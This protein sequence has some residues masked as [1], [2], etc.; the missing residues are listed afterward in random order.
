MMMADHRI[1]SYRYE[2]LN[3]Q[4]QV[5]GP[6]PGVKTGGTL[7]F[8]DTADIRGQGGIEVQ[9][10]GTDWTKHLIRISYVRQGA[11]PLPLITAIPN[12]PG[13]SRDETGTAWQSLDLYDRLII[14]ASDRPLDAYSLADGADVLAAVRGILNGLGISDIVTPDGTRTLATGITWDT[15]VTWLDIINDVLKAANCEPLWCD[16]MGRFRVTDWTDPAARPPVPAGKR[17]PTWES[18]GDLL[19]VPNR[20]KVIGQTEGIWEALVSVA[21]DTNPASPFSYPSRGRWITV[22]E[23]DVPY[24]GGQPELDALA[25]RRLKEF[26]TV[27]ETREQEQP[28]YDDRQLGT[29]LQDASGR[30]VITGMTYPLQTGGLVRTSLRKVA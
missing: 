8:S 27:A 17:L 15:D 6:V 23:A 21:T 19:D 29:V 5:I 3:L 20:V 9:A 4:R 13:I 22:T 30:A 28:V 12:A 25:V 7:T 1:E 2:L 24:T 11:D 10:S 14:P 26:Q 18:A 16:G